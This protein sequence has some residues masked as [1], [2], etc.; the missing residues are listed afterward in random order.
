VTNSEIDLFRKVE[1]AAQRTRLVL[2]SVP[3]AQEM[4]LPGVWGELVVLMY[5]RIRSG[6]EAVCTL[7]S[8]DHP[9]EGLALVRSML[10]DSLILMEFASRPDDRKALALRWYSDSAS[11]LEHLGMTAA[12][13]GLP[14]A[15]DWKNAVAIERKSIQDAM[16][17]H[18]I[19]SL[20]PRFSGDKELAR[21]HDRLQRYFDYRVYSGLIH[22]P[23]LAQKIGRRQVKEGVVQI[24]L[25]NSDPGWK[26]I[27]LASAMD[28]SLFAH[29]AVGSM[30]ESLRTSHVETDSLLA[31][32]DDLFPD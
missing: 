22:R 26:A 4:D 15:E 5:S 28:S 12:E 10:T 30:I 29:T 1:S 21:R 18:G 27:A 23:D 11:H 7:V 6:F 17:T 32:L 8:A 13:V 2:R 19:E 3:D 9:E 16:R 25:R 31:E 24:Y 14:R 20:P